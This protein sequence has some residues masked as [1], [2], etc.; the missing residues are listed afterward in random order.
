VPD[1]LPRELVEHQQLA[2]ARRDRERRV[3][4]AAVDLI[5]LEPRG[6]DD[7]AGTERSARGPQSGPVVLELDVADRRTQRE[8]AAGEDRLGRERER[9]RPRAHDP[10]VGDRQ[11]AASPL[12][13]IRFERTNLGGRQPLRPEVTVVNRGLLNALERSLVILAPRDQHSAR[14][15]KRNAHLGCE[16]T[17]QGAPAGYEARLERPRLGVKARVEDRG[18]RLRGAGSDVDR[19]LEQRDR[20]P[21]AREMSCDRTADDTGPDDG[22]VETVRPERALSQRIAHL[23]GAT[24]ALGGA[25]RPDARSARLTRTSSA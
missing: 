25:P 20:C 11:P 9:R 22:D 2:P 15:R 24:L 3:A 23:Q 13:E 16:G 19:A 6:V 1:V 17:Q 8:I 12:A 4:E 5:R 18:V 10:L 14:D 7:V 21:A